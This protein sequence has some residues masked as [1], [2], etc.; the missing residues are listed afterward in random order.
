MSYR[1]ALEQL[2]IQEY[3]ICI[4]KKDMSGYRI[5][6]NNYGCDESIQSAVVR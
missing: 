6:Y 3:H 4:M 2:F 5:Y 1:L